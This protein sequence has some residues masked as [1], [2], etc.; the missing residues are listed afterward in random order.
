MGNELYVGRHNR[1]VIE[2]YDVATLD[3]RRNL[4]IPG[5][6]CVIDMASCPQCDVVYVS[7]KCDNKI[8]VLDESGVRL[9]WS[10]AESPRGLSVNSQMNVIATFHNSSIL[11]VF[12]PDGEL[13]RNAT[14]ESDVTYPWHTIQLDDDRYIVAHGYSFTNL[15]RV[16]IVNKRGTVIDSFGGIR[17][18]G[19]QQLNRPYR[20]LIF[21]QSLILSDFYNFRLLL[22]SMSPFAYVRDLIT[23]SDG[24]WPRRM[25]L[26]EDGT[27]LFVSYQCDHLQTFNL[28][29][30]CNDPQTNSTAVD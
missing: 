29:W 28:T 15:H 27:Q 9:N 11:R 24:L 4:S 26:S 3:F 1:S 2:V 21:G 5:L 20:I 8:Y 23:R 19:D 18:R 25:A 7:D 22:F 13:L 30:I 10:V 16:C 12:A 14:L 17:G 6:Q